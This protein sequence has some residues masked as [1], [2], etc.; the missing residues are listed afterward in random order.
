MSDSYIAGK[1]KIIQN[2]LKIKKV[3][4]SEIDRAI[5]FRRPLTEIETVVLSLYLRDRSVENTSTDQR[6]IFR[7]TEESFSKMKHLYLKTTD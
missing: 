1:Q 2:L 3:D 6:T 5:V 4:F 7:C